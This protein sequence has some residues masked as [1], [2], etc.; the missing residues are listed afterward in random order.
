MFCSPV[1]NLVSKFANRERYPSQKP[2]H[3][4]PGTECEGV[5]TLGSVLP[6]SSSCYFRKQA[7]NGLVQGCLASRSCRVPVHDHDVQPS[8]VVTLHPETLPHYPLEFVA[9]NGPFGA[10]F[11]HRHTQPRW[12]LVAWTNQ[13]SPVSVG[14]T[15][16]FLEYLTVVCC[17]EQPGG[18]REIHRSLSLVHTRGKALRCPP[19]ELTGEQ[20]RLQRLSGAQACSTLAATRR[21]H[22][23][24]T[25]SSFA[26]AKAV[27]A[28]ALDFARLVSSFHDGCTRDSSVSAAHDINEP[29]IVIRFVCQV[30]TADHLKARFNRLLNLKL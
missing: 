4:F 13:H 7:V 15:F 12:L 21:Q 6:Q 17:C 29:P 23:S 5:V 20:A 3:L 2:L 26:S 25:T 28:S 11:R 1:L 30:N 9:I 22:R 18:T 24:P 14:E 8:Q 19:V 16:V 27:R 10:F